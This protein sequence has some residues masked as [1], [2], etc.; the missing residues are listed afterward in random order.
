MASTTI[1]LGWI[2]L[3]NCAER[4]INLDNSSS[5]TSIVIGT[6]LESFFFI[7]QLAVYGA[8]GLLAT[9]DLRYVVQVVSNTDPM[10]P[11]AYLA[12]VAAAPATIN[13]L[14][15]GLDDSVLFSINY[16]YKTDMFKIKNKKYSDAEQPAEI[17]L[18]L[19]AGNNTPGTIIVA[20]P[21]SGNPNQRWTFET[22]QSTDQ[23]PKFNTVTAASPPPGAVTVQQVASPV[24]FVPDVSPDI[25]DG[26]WVSLNR[27]S[28]GTFTA[29]KEDPEDPTK[30]CYE[31]IMERVT[32]QS[33]FSRDRNELS[34]SFARLSDLPSNILEA[35]ALQTCRYVHSRAPDPTGHCRQGSHM[36]YSFQIYVPTWAG[37]VRE[38]VVT[39]AHWNRIPTSRLFKIWEQ[40]TSKYRLVGPLPIMTAA[41]VWEVYGLTAGGIS[42]S[43]PYD[44][45]EQPVGA[46]PL[47]FKFDKGRLMILYNGDSRWFSDQYVPGTNRKYNPGRAD[48]R[49]QRRVL[50]RE[51]LDEIF[52]VNQWVTFDVDVKWT[53]F[54]SGTDNVAKNGSIKVDMTPNTLGESR[55][56]D[57]GDLLIGANDEYGYFFRFGAH[58]SS[59]EPVHYYFKEYSQTDLPDEQ[60]ELC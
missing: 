34:H 21:D 37:D 1:D 48:P 59:P 24:D 28:Y 5:P 8:Y 47:V 36:R 45:V 56:V 22:Q 2:Q 41:R 35:K 3:E 53:E 32:N 11:V 58:R 40:K 25:I 43:R 60:D 17:V 10:I 6:S 18:N 51:N 52:P 7:F 20:L 50:F 16:D 9:S 23:V 27:G 42:R 15:E 55:I 12:T 30:R 46:P 13:P 49:I 26:E 38:M 44:Y 29:G 39:F 31:F 19:Y 54:V 33:D 14:P 57:A 4:Y